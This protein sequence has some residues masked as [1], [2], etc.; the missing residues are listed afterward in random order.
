VTTEAKHIIQA[1]DRALYR[2]NAPICYL[3]RDGESPA[4][5]VVV[6]IEH[7]QKIMELVPE[8]EAIT[9]LVMYHGHI[10]GEA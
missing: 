7:W 2:A 6:E 10:E 8:G 5:A 9:N 4:F 1:A 3:H